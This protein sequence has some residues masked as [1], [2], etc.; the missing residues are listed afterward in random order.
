MNCDYCDGEM[1]KTMTTYT[2]K[3]NDCV[4]VIENIACNKCEQCGSET[5]DEAEAELISQI[6][7]EIRKIPLELAVTDAKKWKLMKS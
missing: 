1:K 5:Y 6:V 4:I 3:A 2:G 7:K